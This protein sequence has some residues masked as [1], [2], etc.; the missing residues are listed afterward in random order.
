MMQIYCY[1]KQNDCSAIEKTPGRNSY[2][3]AYSDE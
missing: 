2:T 3:L 1:G